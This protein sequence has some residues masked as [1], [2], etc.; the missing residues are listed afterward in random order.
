MIKVD[1]QPAAYLDYREIQDV[2]IADPVW[3]V[4]FPFG[5]LLSTDDDTMFL[6][7]DK[8]RNPEASVSSG[9]VTSLRKDAKGE[10][11]L[12]QT[13]AALNPGN[14]GGAIVNANGNLVAVVKSGISG[15]QGIAF[16]IAPNQLR[17]FF[18]NKAIKVSFHPTSVLDPPQPIHVVVEPILEGVARHKGRVTLEGAD[19][20]TVSIELEPSGDCLAGSL[21]IP[22]RQP[23]VERPESYI[24]TVILQSADSNTEF[25]RRFKLRAVSES[26]QP[27]ESRRDPHDIMDD[28]KYFVNETTIGQEGPPTL[29]KKRVS[30]F[31]DGIRIDSV[32]SQSEVIT[33]NTVR[34]LARKGRNPKHYE[35]LAQQQHRAHAEDLDVVCLELQ[36]L[37]Q[38]IERRDARLQ[39]EKGRSHGDLDTELDDSFEQLINQRQFLYRE[40]KKDNIC[41]CPQS[42]IWFE[43]PKAPCDDCTARCQ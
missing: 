29:Q 32:E 38:K 25:K 14:S 4:G 15:G 43:C 35:E 17:A 34:K 31:A 20:E 16:G 28:R 2:E 26:F 9:M 42:A 36:E 7:E 11:S 33:N 6:E 30:D 1:Y 8:R 18:Q 13:D 5:D 37:T 27:L 39:R 10:L 22:D 19:I 12:I 21:E 24:A 23:G 41:R 40:I 3:A